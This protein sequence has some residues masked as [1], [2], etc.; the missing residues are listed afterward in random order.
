LSLIKLHPFAPWK[1]VTYYVRLA[2]EYKR[3]QDRT[4]P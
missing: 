4:N 1:N 3:K 2:V